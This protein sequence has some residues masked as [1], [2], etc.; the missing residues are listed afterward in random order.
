MYWQKILRIA[1]ALKA[2]HLQ[3]ERKTQSE[4]V[5]CQSRSRVGEPGV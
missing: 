2:A 4:R 5:S 1:L 3:G